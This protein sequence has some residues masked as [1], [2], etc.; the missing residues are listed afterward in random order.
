MVDALRKRP[1]KRIHS[2]R[3]ITTDSEL[4]LIKGGIPLL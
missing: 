2:M 3:D 4:M 1:I